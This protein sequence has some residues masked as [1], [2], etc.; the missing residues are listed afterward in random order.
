MNN[1]TLSTLL[2]GIIIAV[3]AIV[4]FRKSDPEKRRREDLAALAKKLKLRFN[5]DNNFELAEK[6]SY[7]SWLKRGEARYAYNT[8]QGRYLDWQVTVFDYRFSTPTGGRSGG[9][10]Y[11]WSAFIVEMK[12][13]FPDMI[14]S[15]ESRESRLAEA[16]GESHIDFESAAF[17]RTFRVRS[18]D[19]KF[20]YDVCHPKM[21][22]YLLANQDLT[23]EISG[24]GLA[25]LFEDWLRPEKIEFNLSRLIEIRKLL[26]EYLFTKI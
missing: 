12:T 15:H 10:D 11:Y 21:M 2:F 22:E 19:K 24:A 14:I 26:P 16:L 4:S 13:N 17:T 3:L 20:A 18:S 25:V 8:L 7:L 1:N 5:P 23:V 6:F 9:L